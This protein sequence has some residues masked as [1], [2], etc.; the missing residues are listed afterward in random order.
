MKSKRLCTGYQ[1]K[2]AFI[3]SKDMAAFGAG[4]ETSRG[5]SHLPNESSSGPVFYSRWRIDQHDKPC[6]STAKEDPHTAPKKASTPPPSLTIS[7]PSR[8]VFRDQLVDLFLSNQF[9]TEIIER[10][11]TVSK[12][13][14]WMLLVPELPT[15]TPALENAVLAICTARLGRQDG[16]EVLARQ[17]LVLYTTG[18]RELHHA[19]RNP[20]SRSDTQNLAACVALIM[21]ELAECPGGVGGGYLSHYNGAMSL[22]QLRGPDAVTSGLAHSVFHTLR[23]HS[24]S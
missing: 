17:S 11:R 16:H 6:P 20:L 3:L 8:S 9:P 4:P 7:I 10:T 21:Y 13:R 1:K 15:L 14:N 22:L 18:L 12:S 23:M 24:V 5:V 2:H 19:I